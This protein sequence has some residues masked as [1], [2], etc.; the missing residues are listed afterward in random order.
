MDD[1]DSYFGRDREIETCLRRLATSSFLAVVGPSGC[2][3]SSLVRAGVTSRLRRSGRSVAVLTPGHDPQGA[4]VST[5]ATATETTVLVVDQMEELFAPGL[6]AEAAQQFLA[7]LVERLRR[8]TIIVR[9]S[10]PTTSVL[11]A[12]IPPSHAGSKMQGCTSSPP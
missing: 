8:G 2:G 6:P 3:K 5:M 7:A 4:M 12:S 1:D 9:G 10:A 11:S